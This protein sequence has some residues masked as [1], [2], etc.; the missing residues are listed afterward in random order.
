MFHIWYT[1]QTFISYSTISQVEVL[2]TVHLWNKREKVTVHSIKL[3]LGSWQNSH[4]F[5]CYGKHHSKRSGTILKQL[6]PLSINYPCNY[7]TTPSGSRVM[8]VLSINL[9]YVK[10]WPLNMA[11]HKS[12]CSYVLSAVH[13]NFKYI[14]LQFTKTMRGFWV[15]LHLVAIIITMNFLRNPF[16]LSMPSN[17][18]I[19]W[20]REIIR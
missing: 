18:V 5:G 4:S 12:M 14:E 6:F 10:W 15:N 8:T 9:T 7:C 16:K 13:V 11:I 3:G 2:Y 1:P 19:D 17:A 20:Y